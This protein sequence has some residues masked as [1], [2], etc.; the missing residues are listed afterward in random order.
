LLIICVLGRLPIIGV[1][2]SIIFI[3]IAFIIENYKP[4]DLMLW[5]NKCMYFGIN[6]EG[7][8]ALAKDEDEAFA[9]LWEK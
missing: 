9:K 4:N 5:I 7:L 1:I 6:N 3:A 8:F 2:I